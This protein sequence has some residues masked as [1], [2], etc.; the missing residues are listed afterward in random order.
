MMTKLERIRRDIE[1]LATFNATPGQGLTRFSLTTQ[2]R[3]ARGY[4]REEMR[5]CG[6]RI[7]EDEAGNL[8]GRREGELAGA[9]VVMIG[10][11]FDSVTKGGNFDGPAGVSVALETVRVLQEKGIRTKYPIEVVA[12][13]EEEGG[14]FGA[15][16]YGS[17]AMT[18][19]VDAVQLR[20]RKDADGVSMYDALTA[21]GFD[22]EKV[23][24]ARRERGT[25][26]AFLE[27]HIEQGPI[28]ENGGFDIGIVRNVVGI[29]QLR[30]LVRGRQGHAGTTPME[31]RSDALDAAAKVI[32]RIADAAK[33][34]GEGTV[35]T[36]GWVAV[37]PGGFNIIPAEAEFSV[38]IRSSRAEYAESVNQKV[39]ELLA[40]HCQ[41]TGTE[42]EVTQLMKIVPVEMGLDIVG[43]EQAACEK[44]GLKSKDMS[45]GAGHDAMVMAGVTDA[46]LLFVPSREGRS[47]CPEEWTDYEALQKGAEVY[48]HTVLKLADA[49]L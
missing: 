29:H 41:A 4:I 28:L 9:P 40:V 6:L 34:A 20:E 37:K 25:I 26:K 16:L 45:S 32:S 10:S 38:D 39:K 43:I 33:D 15:G 22:P 12:L 36:V 31:L 49:L 27:L 30:V 13:I 47:H 7:F 8:I 46:G 2:D 18:G 17:R 42:Y 44:L 3:A 24:G 11:H 5:G 21:F 19:K 14:R 35:A 1:E 23:G 48:L